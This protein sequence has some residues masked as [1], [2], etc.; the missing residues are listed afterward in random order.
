MFYSFFLS[1]YLSFNWVPSPSEY[2]WSEIFEAVVFHLVFGI[3]GTGLDEYYLPIFIT[4][5]FIIDGLPIPNIKI[6]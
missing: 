2:I 1:K 5:I 6:F 3:K 4:I